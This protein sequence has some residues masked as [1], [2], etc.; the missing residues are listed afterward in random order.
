M[1]FDPRVL[2]LSTLTTIVFV[3]RFSLGL[4]QGDR[5]GRFKT[6]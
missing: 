6:R 3:K 1:A 4:G 5:L 2:A